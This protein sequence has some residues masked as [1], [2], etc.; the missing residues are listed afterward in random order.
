MKKILMSST[1]FAAVFSSQIVSA[2][3]QTSTIFS[4]TTTKGKVV[5]VCDSGKTIDYSFGKKGA[6]PELAL[7][8]PRAEVTTTQWDGTTTG[9]Y[10]SVLIPNGNTK[11]EV[12]SNVDRNAQEESSGIYVFINGNN[13]ATITCKTESV[14]DNLEGVSLSPTP[15]E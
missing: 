6:K 8:V 2:S 12:F 5:E 7:S 1:I 11:Y 13:A 3:C 9:I 15:V 14:V 4:C 10:Y